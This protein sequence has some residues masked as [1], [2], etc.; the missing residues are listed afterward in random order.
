MEEQAF[1]K[2]K[3][4]ERGAKLSILAYICLSI[5][6]LVIGYMA[7]SE[8]LKADGLNNVT[9]ILASIAVLIGLKL[10]QRPADDVFD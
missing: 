7:N 8:A 3:R 6:K 2:L 9:D 1:L 5:L 4:G 10:S